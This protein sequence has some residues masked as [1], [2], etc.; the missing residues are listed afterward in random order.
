MIKLQQKNAVKVGTQQG[1]VVEILED[2]MQVKALSHDH[3]EE[4]EWAIEMITRNKLYTVALSEETEEEKAE[5]Q[6]IHAWLM[7]SAGEV[8]E[9]EEDEAP[10]EGR[11]SRMSK[12]GG[13][14][15]KGINTG[16]VSR[17]GGSRMV[18]G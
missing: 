3:R 4:I 13:S 7:H 1:I 12:L 15:A 2:L 14:L 16:T 10:A 9:A 11:Q 18:G 5:T 6:A 17:M 8:A